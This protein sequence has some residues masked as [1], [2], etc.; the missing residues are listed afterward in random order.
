[1]TPTLSLAASNNKE[2]DS[3]SFGR[4]R[5]LISLTSYREAKHFVISTLWTD[6]LT[7]S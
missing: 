1:L 6:Q 2:I 4:I 7:I 3:Y 5:A